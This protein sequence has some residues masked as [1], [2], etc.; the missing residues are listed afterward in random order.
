MQKILFVCLGNICRSPLAEGIML[1]LI[2]DKNLPIEIDSAGTSNFHAGET[3]DYRTLLNAKKHGVDLTPLKARQFSEKD[4]NKFDTIY[5]MDKSNMT[6]VLAL[7]K[8]KEQEQKVELFLNA[9]F[10]N[11]NREVPDPYFG[12]EEGF[13]DVFNLVYSTCEKMIEKYS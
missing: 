6:N 10:P 13:E 11:Q 4:F 2:S 5:V 7:A 1:K 8:N 3:P 9:L 12:G